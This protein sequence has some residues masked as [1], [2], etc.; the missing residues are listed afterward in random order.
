MEK[1]LFQPI[2]DT[3]DPFERSQS[4]AAHHE[5]NYEEQLKKVG[6]EV[7]ALYQSKKYRNGE[8]ANEII[9]TLK[10]TDKIKKI[11]N[12]HRS[13]PL[14]EDWLPV[15]VYCENC[16]TDKIKKTTFDGDNIIKYECDN[17]GHHG[18]ENISSTTRVKLPW[19]L[20]WLDEVGV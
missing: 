12:E 15:S 7:E 1:Y 2:V 18:E 6:I 10:N 9:K 11:L 20:D 13:S 8:Y 5:E 16:N 4:Y 14:S 17:C 3:P 19:R